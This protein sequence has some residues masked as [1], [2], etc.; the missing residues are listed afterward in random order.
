MKRVVF[1]KIA[2]F[3]LEYGKASLFIKNN[4]NEAPLDYLTF[5]KKQKNY[6]QNISQSQKNIMDH[7]AN[8]N[9]SV[10]LVNYSNF[11]SN[12][13]TIDSQIEEVNLKIEDLS[14]SKSCIARQTN[15]KQSDLKIFTKNNVNI[16][17][18]SF[19]CIKLI[20]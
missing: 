15:K 16:C 10:F 17:S 18:L 12:S 13:S 4:K 20:F 1:L 19:F 5:S 8:S 3:L 6:H 9:L 11:L 7:E 14:N 2:C